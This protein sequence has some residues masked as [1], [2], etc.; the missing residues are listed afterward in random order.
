METK[1]EIKKEKKIEFVA[2]KDLT[3]AIIKEFYLLPVRMQKTTS[4]SGF[5]RV[6]ISIEIDKNF[7]TVQLTEQRNNKIVPLSVDRF[8]QIFLNLNLPLKDSTG[9][10]LTE[11]LF[12]APIRFVK[13]VYENGDEYYSLEIVFK[14]YLYQV[15]F[16]TN[17]QKKIIDNLVEKK[18]FDYKFID[19]PDKINN[20]SNDDEIILDF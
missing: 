17:V 10:P 3:P 13:G 8:N 9:R 20:L 2:L 15:Y 6:S 19:R 5:E 12:K 18:S 14:Q 1:T 7:L 4:R 16:F 11:W